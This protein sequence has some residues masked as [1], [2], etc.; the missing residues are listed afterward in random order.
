MADRKIT[1]LAN[2]TGANLADAD[3]FVVVDASADETKAITFA[4]LKSGLDTATG[5]VRITGDTMTGNLD[6]QGTLTSDGLTVD[7]DG[8]L[9]DFSRNGDAVAGQLKYVDADTG[10][11]FGTTTNHDWYGISN[12]T[13]RLKVDNSGDISF[14]EDTGTSPKFFWDASAESLGVGHSSAPTSMLAVGG[15]AT[16]TAKPTVA[17]VDTTSGATMTLRGQSP[18]LSF[19]ITSGGVGKILMD[20]AGLEFK[21]GTLDAEGN[22]DVKIDSSGNLL[23]GKTSSGGATVGAELRPNGDSF[24]TRASGASIQARRNGSDGEIA[25][26]YKDSDPVGN[27]GTDNSGD[28][29]IGNDDT[30]I[31]F[32]GG[33]DFVIPW[34]P[35][36]PAAR[37]DAISL[38]GS[39]HRFK[40]LYLSGSIHGDTIFENNAGTTEYARFDSSGNLLVGM[41]TAST[42]NDGAGIRADGLI[43]GKRADVVATFN[44]K[45]TDGGIIELAKDN[46]IVGS[47]GTS[48]VDLTIGT[49]DVGLKFNDA[50]NRIDPW[51]VTTNTS[52]DGTFDLG[53]DD[54]RFKDLH[55]SG[56]LRGDITFKNNAGTT[57]YA[58]FDGSGNLLV[59]KTSAAYNTDGFQIQSNGISGATTSAGRPFFA[60]RKG[61]DGAIIDLYK[62]GTTVGSI[63]TITASGVALQ[64]KGAVSAQPVDIVTKN[65]GGSDIT[66]R[67][68][69][70]LG[71][72]GPDATQNLGRSTARWKD[73][74]LSGGV[75]LGG[76][77]SANLLDDYEEGTWTPAVGGATT[78]PTVTYTS[79]TGYYTKIGR[80]VHIQMF[81][82]CSAVSG[83]SGAVKVTGIPFQTS[84]ASNSYGAAQ[85]EIIGVD[86][87]SDRNNIVV[88]LNPNYGHF[89]FEFLD[90]RASTTNGSSG[91][92]QVSS[93][94]NS[95]RVLGSFTYM[96]DA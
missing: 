79:Q 27:I 73:L 22:V 65:S 30:G 64:V 6:I 93:L 31:L 71:F 78:D 40:N 29:F 70:S 86:M 15:N 32:A 20:G 72:Y 45:T 17:I 56:G 85:I 28:L 60:N 13:K 59:G 12:D 75:Y 76:T 26:F 92:L 23:V 61:S 58:R 49:G 18:K 52:V 82:N 7:G 81:L 39:S 47:I 41:T 37:D 90:N 35:S 16:T 36:T 84:T 2:I 48:G 8:T 14:Y 57:E 66:Y 43:H 67:F 24:F 44:R 33:S 5:F 42:S 55:L 53:K 80:M 46:A 62:D 94:G 96:T 25:I 69:D 77:G 87:P 63:G 74:Y 51:N 91:G 50:S 95:F 9:L 4:E 89:R 83:G 54:R 34:N 19:D 3:E 11:H 21:D 10:F 1:E 88:R 68:H 38:G